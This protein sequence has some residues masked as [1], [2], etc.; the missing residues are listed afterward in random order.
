MIRTLSLSFLLMGAVALACWWFSG[1]IGHFLG[2]KD[3]DPSRYPYDTSRYPYVS[4]H[5]PLQLLLVIG[6]PAFLMGF[7]FL[8]FDLVRRR[9]NTP[10]V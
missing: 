9:R 6:V 2:L 7:G 5:W 1:S 10:H 3:F 4:V 8:V